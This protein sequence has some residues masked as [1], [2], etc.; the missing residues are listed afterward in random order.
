MR[1]FLA[2]A[3]VLVIPVA[4]LAGDPQTAILDVQNMTCSVCPITVK[5]SLQKVPGVT[6]AKID[7]DRGTATV[8]FDT[9]KA[10]VAALVKATTEAGF[11]STARK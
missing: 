7:L 10:D 8:R 3:V 9:G 1:N 4:V 2:A 5:K 6:D 11:P